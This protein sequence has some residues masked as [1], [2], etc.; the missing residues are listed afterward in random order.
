MTPL[1]C[2]V[3]D[4]EPLAIDVV[5]GYLQRLD[6]DPVCCDN[7]V[8]ALRLLQEQSFD[9]AFLDIGMPGLNGID[10]VKKLS[11]RPAIVITAPGTA[12]R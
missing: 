4:D 3:A 6:L 8:E 9:L 5:V 10:L 1:K 2:L 7:G 11:H 12:A